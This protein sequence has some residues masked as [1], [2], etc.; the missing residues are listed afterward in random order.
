MPEAKIAEPTEFARWKA[1]GAPL[2][3]DHLGFTETVICD[4]PDGLKADLRLA[5]GRCPTGFWFFISM[6]RA[7]EA[8]F[9]ALYLAWQARST[10][11]FHQYLPKAN[12]TKPANCGT[13]NT[14]PCVVQLLPPTPHDPSPKLPTVR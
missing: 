11:G 10:A 7:Q 4:G 3:A 14:P 5:Y 1:S 2:F 9:H 8:E 12:G 13:P 6:T